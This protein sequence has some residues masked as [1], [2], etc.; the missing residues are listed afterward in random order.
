MPTGYRE[1]DF[2]LIVFF[3]CLHDMAD[4][5]GAAVAG[6]LTP[7]GRLSY[8]VSSLVCVPV[9]LAQNGPALGALG[10]PTL[11]LPCNNKVDR[12]QFPLGDRGAGVERLP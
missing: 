12:P 2:D 10:D 11:T 5:A 7:L 8:G 3:D 9:S 6:N 4:P 1:K